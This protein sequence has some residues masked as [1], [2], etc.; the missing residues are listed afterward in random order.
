MVNLSN[1]TKANFNEFDINL[2]QKEVD[3]GEISKEQIDSI[4]SHT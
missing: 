4:G 1:Y 3:G 2:V